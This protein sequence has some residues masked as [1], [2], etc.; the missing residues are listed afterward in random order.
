MAE[1]LPVFKQRGVQIDPYR[2]ADFSPLLR[3]SRNVQQAQSRILER[4][5]DYATKIGEQEAAQSG[6]ESVTGVEE[7]KSVL[8]KAKEK[9]VPRTIYDRAAYDQANEVLSLELENQGRAMFSEKVRQYKQDP[10]AD[11]IKFRAETGDI[12]L[13]LDNLTS[14]LDPKIRARVA[15]GLQRT[16]DTA[17]LEISEIYNDRVAKEVQSKAI[18]G[19]SQRISDFGRLGASG[20]VTA[21]SELF[22]EINDLRQ[23]ASAG[24]LSPIDVERSIINGIEQFHIERLRKDFTKSP[25]KAAFLKSLQTDLGKGPVG[26]LFDDKGNPIKADRLSRGI[27]PAKLNALVNEFE[28]DIRA[29]NAQVRALRTEVKGDITE[30]LRIFSLGA[31]PDPSVVSDLQRRV[32]ALG[33]G[34]DKDIVRQVNYLGVLRQQSIAFSKMNQAQLGDWIRNAEQQTASGANLEQAMLIDV[35]RKTFTGLR[36]DL[37]KDPVSRMNRTGFSEVKTLDFTRPP[38]E[39]VANIRERVSQSKSFAATQ[40]LPTPKFLSND[41]ASLMSSFLENA[42]IDNQIA[43]L[44]TLNEGF[45]KDTGLVMSEISKFSPEFAHVGGLATVG[46]NKTTLVDALNGIKLSKEGV[47][48]FEGP[49]DAATKKAQLAD[50]LGGAY[51][52]AP[53][54]RQ[55]IVKVA[56]SIYLSRSVGMDKT[57]F[58]SDLYAQ[59]FQEAAG[60]VMYKDGR[61]RGGIIEHRGIKLAI[62]NTIRQDDFEDIID[63]ATFEDFEAAAGSTPKDEKGRKYTVERLRDAFLVSR[64]N[65][66]AVMFYDNPLDKS[67]PVAFGTEDGQQLVVDLSVLADRVNQRKNR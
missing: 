64:D 2:A 20:K 63:E 19:V 65:K 10:N 59:A 56:D 12:A 28:A 21:E 18:A 38:D 11:P 47:K 5:I 13:G 45:G 9:G 8:T 49:G 29:Q 25:N 6:R 34:A 3:E 22:L 40:G 36:T 26:D 31:I 17:F 16:R 57:V 23:Y 37:E 53:K 60:G 14:Q 30:T 62:P 43:F 1:R 61:M 35:A 41:E 44:G 50:Q 15:A 67:N 54:T 51:I 24:Q 46:A 42:P 55:A 66:T 52:Y 33:P 32:A 39:L 27:D 7:A 4:V 48:T 58:D